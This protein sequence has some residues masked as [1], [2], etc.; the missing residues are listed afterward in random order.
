MF[1]H[2]RHEHHPDPELE[3]DKPKP[4]FREET[5]DIDKPHQII[6]PGHGIEPGEALHIG[7]VLISRDGGKRYEIVA[8]PDEAGSSLVRLRSLDIGKKDVFIYVLEKDIRKGYSR[9]KPT[10]EEE[11]S[12]EEEA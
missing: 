11:S 10:K 2:H 12:Q 8:L 9:R 7:D 4:R 1:E 6:E 3:K 5:P